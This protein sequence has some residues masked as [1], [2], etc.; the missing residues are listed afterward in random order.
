MHHS[1]LILKVFANKKRLGFPKPL[2]ILILKSERGD[3]DWKS[4]F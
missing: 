1:R 4:S 2:P 3:D